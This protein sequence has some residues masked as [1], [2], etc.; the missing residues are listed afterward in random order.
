MHPKSDFDQWNPL[1]IQIFEHQSTHRDNLQR[2]SSR[3]ASISYKCT[4]NGRQYKSLI[5]KCKNH[6]P[7]RLH[8]MQRWRRESSESPNSSAN[9]THPQKR[10]TKQCSAKSNCKR[11]C[12]IK[13]VNPK[14]AL[15][16]HTTSNRIARPDQNSKT[17]QSHKQIGG[18]NT[19]TKAQ[20]RPDDNLR[21]HDDTTSTPN[22]ENAGPSANH[23]MK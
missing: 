1:K 9:R 11:P 16:A 7:S 15:I 18:H 10:A 13:N 4:Q 14:P 3:F 23:D 17:H 22:L 21:R 12:S 6:R 8:G 2:P 5:V 19:T 20:A